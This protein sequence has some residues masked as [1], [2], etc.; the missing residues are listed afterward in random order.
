MWVNFLC[1]L[2]VVDIFLR[3]KT[4]STKEKVNIFD[5]VKA[6]TISKIKITEY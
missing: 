3:L 4:S 1:N 5:Y 2:K 6:N